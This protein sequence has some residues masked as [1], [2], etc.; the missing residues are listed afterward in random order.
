NTTSPNQ[1]PTYPAY[2]V[3]GETQTF[4]YDTMGR[5]LTADNLDAK[6]KRSYYPGGLL[7]TDS[8]R[9]QTVGR[10]DWNQHKYGLQHTYDLDGRRLSLAVPQ[11]LLATVL[12]PTMTFSY[13]PQFGQLQTVSD[14]HGNPYRFD[15][16]LRGDLDSLRYPGSYNERFRYD[17]DGRLLADTIRN[18]GGTALPRFTDAI[19]RAT[20]YVYDAQARVL[21]SRD[22]LGYKDTL[23]VTY[24]GLGHLAT[25]TLAEHGFGGLGLYP[26]RFVSA[27]TFSFDALGNR[28]FSQTLDTFTYPGSSTNNSTLHQ[29]TYQSGTGRMVTDVLNTMTT[30]YSYDGAGNIAFTSNPGFTNRP[31][32]E[33]RSH[34][35]ADGTLRAV[36]WRWIAS[37]TPDFR[38]EK[39]AVDEYRYDAL[40]RRVWVWSKKKC[41][42]VDFQTNWRPHVECITSLMRRTVWD[43]DHELAEIQM[44]GGTDANEVALREND[45][46]PTNLPPLP[47]CIDRM[48]YFGRVFYTPGRAIDQPLAVTR[49]NYEDQHSEDNNQVFCAPYRLLPPITTMP[50]WNRNGDP[51][52]GAYTTG[53]RLIHCQP[54]TNPTSRCVAPIW[55]FFFS[56]YD[57]TRISERTDWHGTVLEGKRDESGLSYSRNRY[58]DPATGRFTQEDPIGL[59]GGLNLYGFANG[60]PVNFGDPFGLQ[61]CDKG[62]TGECKKSIDWAAAAKQWLSDRLDDV[63]QMVGGVVD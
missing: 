63:V 14:L 20:T 13:H 8:L 58:Y 10:T 5:L 40:G 1:A 38:P 37:T 51:A 16:S 32:E 39:Y 50:F 42:Y 6:V 47:N 44:P 52:L 26:A 46:A 19:I 22:P 3:P 21:S 23:T 4:T 25:S 28:Y 61:G 7:K 45:V 62:A 27:E 30:T 57:R 49:V 2:Q 35:A 56:A 17:A 59:A 29:S 43:G 60:D 34:F 53:A 41:F 54:P 9:I 15:Y 18:L 11:Q 12:L 31:G 55:S 36:D 48:Q 24:S 33:R